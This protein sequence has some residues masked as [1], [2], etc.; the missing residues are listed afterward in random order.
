MPPNARLLLAAIAGLYCGQVA[1]WTPAVVRQPTLDWQPRSD[2]LDAKIHCG[3]VGDGA[4][5]DSA[6][7]QK[8]LANMTS[9]SALHIPAGTY[10]ITRTLE[11]GCMNNSRREPLHCGITAGAVIGHGAQTVLEWAGAVNGTMLWVHGVTMSRYVGLHFDCKNTAATAVNHSSQTLY[12][13]EILHE[14]HRFSNCLGAAVTV[15]PHAH[16]A[17]AETLWSNVL[18]ENNG[19]GL[20]LGSF[21]DYDNTFGRHSPAVHR[22]A[23]KAAVGSRWLPLPQQRRGDVAWFGKRLRAQLPVRKLE[24][25]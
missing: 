21:N 7:L 19:V 25:V 14:N 10:R 18:W 6:A 24:P 13:T 22:T 3:A 5:D 17:T 12:E 1:G 4:A 23:L 15:D 20:Q 9:G 11:I 16:V 2:W 8:C